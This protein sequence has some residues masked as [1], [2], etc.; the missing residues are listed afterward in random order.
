MSRV[1]LRADGTGGGLYGHPAGHGGLREAIARH[2]TV[3]RGVQASAEDVTVTSGTQQALDVIARVLLAP[4]DGVAVEDPGYPPPRRLFATL[5][6]RV[7]AV[8]VDAQG[9]VV[10]A[11]PRRCGSCT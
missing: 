5:G 3:S 4:G 1:A 9:L 8:P 7:D 6:A 2:V 11:L 10:D